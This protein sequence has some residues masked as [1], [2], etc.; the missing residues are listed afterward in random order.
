MVYASRVDNLLTLGNAAA[1]Q[2]ASGKAKLFA[3][4]STVAFF[5][6]LIIVIAVAACAGTARHFYG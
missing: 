2:E 3:T 4:I 6:W 5:V 1:A